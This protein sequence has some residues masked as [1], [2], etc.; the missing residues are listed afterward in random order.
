MKV[1]KYIPTYVYKDISCIEY[2]KIKA[3]NKVGK[4]EITH[5][6]FDLDNT[7]CP[8]YLDR[9]SKKVIDIINKIKNMGFV[10]VIISNSPESRVSKYAKELDCDYVFRANK[11]G[12][13]KCLE[14]INKLE[15]FKENVLLVGDQLLTDIKCA[16]DLGVKSVLVSTIDRAKQK[17]YT[18]L[19]RLREKRILK[20][21]KTIDRD[22]Y[23]KIIGV[24][25]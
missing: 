17:W 7:L 2:Q 11:P 12:I 9:P 15:I 16:N 13:A 5:I 25:K 4:R 22:K 3:N 8:Y 14:E 1:E 21:I 19:N 20:L 10:V 23:S 6:F 18:K 24:N